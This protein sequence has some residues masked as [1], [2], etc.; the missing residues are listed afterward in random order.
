MKLSI[1]HIKSLLISLLIS[2]LILFAFAGN[3]FR[4]ASDTAALFSVSS[5]QDGK[6][7]DDVPLSAYVEQ[8]PDV[9]LYAQTLESFLWCAF[10]LLLPLWL[11]WYLLLCYAARPTKGVFRDPDRRIY[12]LL[13]ILRYIVAAFVL[14]FLLTRRTFL[15][16][17]VVQ[18][19]LYQINMQYNYLRWVFAWLVFTCLLLDW[20]KAWEAFRHMQTSTRTFLL[21][22]AV[23]YVCMAL[24]ELLCASKLYLMP[25]M[26][27]LN[28]VFWVLVEIFLYFLFQRRV[29]PAGLVTLAAAYFVGVA[30]HVVFQLRGSYVTFGDLTAVGTALEVAGNYTFKPGRYFWLTLGIFLAAAVVILLVRLPKPQKVSAKH[31]VL[32]LAGAALVAAAAVWGYLSGMLYHNVNGVSWDYSIN[33]AHVGYVPFFLSNMHEQSHV[34]CEGYSPEAALAALDSVPDE[35]DNSVSGD[36]GGSTSRNTDSIASGNTD[37]NA[38]GDTDKSVPGKS[39]DAEAAAQEPNIIIIQN[40]AFS[41]L[42]MVYDL[43][44]D[45]DTLP[46]IHSLA[47]NTAKGFL[48]LSVMVGPTANTEFEVL[49]RSSLA[50]LPYGCIPYSQYINHAIPSLAEALKGQEIP[51]HTVAYHSYYSSGYSRTSAYH[52]LGFDESVFE[53]R[54]MDDFASEQIFRD[55]VTDEA[56]FDRVIQL[57]EKSR[58]EYPDNPFFCFNVTIQNHGG[59]YGD[60]EF[61]EPVSVTNF[62]APEEL[63]TYLSLIRMSDDAFRKLTEYFAEVDEPT[64]LVMYG[65]HQP[66]FTDKDVELLGGHPAWED[67]QAQNISR[68][69]VPYVIWANYDIEEADRMGTDREQAKLNTLSA[70]Y[71]GSTVLR[72]AGL[73][74]SSYDRYLLDLQESV[75]AL[76]ALG[77]WTADGTYYDSAQ[78]GPFADEL[79]ELQKIQYNLL[80]DSKEKLW[81]K[82]VP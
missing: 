79:A 15:W 29:K 38:S 74:L 18:D 62:D 82:F 71:L 32:S 81:E 12:G 19:Y 47:E 13:S 55:Y 66:S 60:Y 1:S 43:E 24:V 48:N 54:F 3:L 39:P 45:R 33:I 34:E 51:Y 20:K 73:E 30:N 6:M 22:L 59:Y 80:I 21:L 37:G 28:Y 70:N 5:T 67:E 53:D 56:N 8:H 77:Y 63:E 69:Y 57:Y 75:P 25:S 65:D 10:F 44:T 7:L 40:E 17:D 50:F 76:S 31:R 72:Y 49:T 52:H 46:F 41:D 58:G 16:N 27:I 4:A 64:I 78:A 11:F 14:S 23:P 35:T 42:S 2:A 36:T 61:E 68:H 9:D 26:C